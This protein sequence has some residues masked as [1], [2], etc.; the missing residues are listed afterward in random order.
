MRA[1]VAVLIAAA[2]LTC[3]PDDVREA[4][5]GYL[6]IEPDTSAA[7]VWWFDVQRGVQ[8]HRFSFPTRVRCEE[9]R[10]VAVT[11]VGSEGRVDEKCH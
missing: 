1:L 2:P 11:L 5:P 6:A 7:C 4:C 8:I 3:L 9:A 10:Q